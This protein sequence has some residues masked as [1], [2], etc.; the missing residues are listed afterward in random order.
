MANAITVTRILL[1]PFVALLALSDS[2]T[3]RIA[4]AALYGVA[5]GTDW[6]DGYV[7]RS[8]PGR[9][10]ELGKVLDPLADRL[11]IV[12]LVIILYVRLEGLLPLWIL[13]L[14]AARELAGVVGY[15]ILTAKG[16]RPVV[17]YFGK[18]TTAL[19]LIGISIVLVGS[20]FGSLWLAR[21]GVF[22]LLLAGVAHIFSG[23]SYLVERR[24]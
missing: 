12:T 13:G 22:W 3:A 9:V 20:A 11:L 15:Q 23:L 19:I 5:A 16:R 10:T 1:I 14:I 8:G 21:T 6:L 4:G 18:V 17:N 7:A 24:S 2:G